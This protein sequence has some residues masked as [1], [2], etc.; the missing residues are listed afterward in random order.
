MILRVKATLSEF[1]AACSNGCVYGQILGKQGMYVYAELGKER[2]YRSIPSD[3]PN[4]EYRI[5]RDCNIYFAKTPEQLQSGNLE[6]EYL[7]GVGVVIYH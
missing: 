4:T 6:A 7:A 3:D 2:E 5:F 1:N